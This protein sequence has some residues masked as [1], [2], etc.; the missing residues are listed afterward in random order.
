MISF[1]ASFSE[2]EY[3]EEDEDA[4]CFP[5]SGSFLL[6]RAGNSALAFTLLVA[7]IGHMQ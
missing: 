3:E 6:L 1:Y 2:E 5:S 7:F 4:D